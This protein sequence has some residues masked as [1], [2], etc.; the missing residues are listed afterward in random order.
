MPPSQRSSANPQRNH[1]AIRQVE[2]YKIFRK[3]RENKSFRN[4]EID[5]KKN[6][7]TAEKIFESRWRMLF[8]NIHQPWIRLEKRIWEPGLT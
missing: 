4:Q 7:L 1:K 2:I 8:F 3:I 6:W 5:T